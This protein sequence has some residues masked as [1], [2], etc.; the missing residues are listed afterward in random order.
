MLGRRDEDALPQQAGSVADARD[1]AHVCFDLEVVEIDAAE[2]DSR[3]CGR[4]NEPQLAA[5]GRVKTHAFDFDRS[6][7]CEFGMAS[8]A[9]PI[10]QGSSAT[11]PMKFS[12]FVFI[13]GLPG[14]F[15]GMRPAHV[16]DIQHI[17]PCLCVGLNRSSGPNPKKSPLTGSSPAISPR[18]FRARR[19]RRMDREFANGR[20][21]Q[22][23]FE[24][25]LNA[26]PAAR[27]PRPTGC[28]CDSSEARITRS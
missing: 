14:H 23:S 1:V 13:H 17:G 11:A 10:L 20:T 7:N 27:D 22:H 24:R 5:N 9:V 15:L 19:M 2:H 21:F 25:S 12:A 16:A 28:E 4:R 26:A 6:L 18:L 8:R 3:V